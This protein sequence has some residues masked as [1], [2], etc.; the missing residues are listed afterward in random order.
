MQLKARA[1]ANFTQPNPSRKFN[2][3]KR[4]TESVATNSSS[5]LDG[6]GLHRCQNSEGKNILLPRVPDFII[7]GK[8]R[9]GFTPIC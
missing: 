1:M 4:G 6:H 2:L 3:P 9:K 5:Y 8:K 7:G